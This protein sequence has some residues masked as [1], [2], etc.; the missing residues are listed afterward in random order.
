MTAKQIASRR[1]ETKAN[2]VNRDALEE[3]LDRIIEQSTDDLVERARKIVRSHSKRSE[4]L[5]AQA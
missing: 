2:M 1:P 5:D 3:Q 4:K